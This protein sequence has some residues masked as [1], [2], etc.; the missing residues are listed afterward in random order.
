MPQEEEPDLGVEGVDWLPAS[1]DDPECVEVHPIE[2]DEDTIRAERAA[3]D[4]ATVGSGVSD[5]DRARGAVALLRNPLIQ[6]E[7]QASSDFDDEA[8]SLA[9]DVFAWSPSLGLLDTETK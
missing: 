3:L 6:A 9:A 2:E 1:D 4:A 5:I 8:L 7:L